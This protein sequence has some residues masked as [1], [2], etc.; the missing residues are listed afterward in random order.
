MVHVNEISP[1]ASL[2]GSRSRRTRIAVVALTLVLALA[3][4]LFVFT[5]SDGET[6]T[7]DGV[8]A[9]LSVDGIPNGIAAGSDA[10][11]VALVDT[12]ARPGGKLVRLNLASGAVERTVPV[13]GVLSFT[14]RIGGSVWTVSYDRNDSGPGESLEVDW[15]T[16]KVLHRLPF[17][18]PVLG[19]DGGG[20]ALW[21]V[22]G[23]SPATLVRLDPIRV[24]PW[25]LLFASDG[26][27]RPVPW[28]GRMV[29]D[30]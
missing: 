27:G 3:G 11:W 20:G 26:E 21:F 6:V 17:D 28:R 16:G 12:F 5:R 24:S 4:A 29:R 25:W 22:V 13:T 2:A 8:A 30:R 19:F 9:V 15:A 7:T 18:R 10:V 1:N 14:K 23:R